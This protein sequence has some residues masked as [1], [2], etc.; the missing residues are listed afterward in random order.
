MYRLAYFVPK[1]LLVMVLASASAPAHA[2]GL[3]ELGSKPAKKTIVPIGRAPE[4]KSISLDL[5]SLR[6]R[7]AQLPPPPLTRRERMML[8]AE[9]AMSRQ[10]AVTNARRQRVSHQPNRRVNEEVEYDETEGFPVDSNGDPVM[11]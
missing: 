5:G 2:T 7:E 10:Q 1:M 8:R 6:T 11:E 4:K 9:R 3:V